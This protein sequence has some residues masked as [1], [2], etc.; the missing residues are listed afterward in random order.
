MERRA[1]VKWISAFPLLA[2]VGIQQAF[3]TGW[4][5]VAKDSTDNIYT[6]LGVKPVINGRGTWT[7]LSATLELPEVKAAQEA[8]SQHYVNIFEL[9]QA[10]GKRLGVLTGAES[11]M[12]T[13]GAAAAIASGT[14]ACLAGTDPKAIWQLP[15]TTGLKHEVVMVGG[16]SPFDSAIRLAGGKLVVVD[17]S[18]QM[19]NAITSNTAMIYTGSQPEELSKE[20]AIA[21]SRGVP[22]F[23]DAA[24]GIPPVENIR[25]FAKMGC[26]LYTVSGGKGL[27]GPQSTGVLLGR[28]DLIEAALANTSPWEGAVCRPMKVGKEEIM[29]CLAAVETLFHMDMPALNKEWTSR[30]ERIATLAGTVPGVQTKIFTPTMEN[31]YPT[32]NISWD[33]KA[34]GYSTQDCVKELL[35][36]TPSIAVMSNNNPSDVLGRIPHEHAERP[37]REDKLQIISMTLKP[38][39]DIIVGKRLRQLLTAARSKA[40]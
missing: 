24:D 16:R 23:M 9:Q 20:I 19:Q 25:L 2:Q 37:G 12:I 34:W 18:E 36:G 11:G 7:Y 38:G 28:K 8:A 15:D 14:A 5:E 33:Q 39:E 32:L 4:A 26:D 29:G 30:V 35:D 13:S 27:C 40:A 17:S 31:Q 1:F 3:G 10:V 21:K 6:R 22:I